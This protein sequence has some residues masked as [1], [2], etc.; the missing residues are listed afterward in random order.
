MSHRFQ[1][2]QSDYVSL[3]V[4]R[5]LLPLVSLDTYVMGRREMTGRFILIEEVRIWIWSHLVLEK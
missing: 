3:P 1:V 4:N 5:G 2:T